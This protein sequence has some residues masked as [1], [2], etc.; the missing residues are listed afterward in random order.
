[1]KPTLKP[2]DPRLTAFALDE[3]SEADRP[4]FAAE[5]KSAPASQQLL[6]EVAETATILREAFVLEEIPTGDIR[7]AAERTRRHIARP[8]IWAQR[9][10]VFAAAASV[11]IAIVGAYSWM[12]SIQLRQQ[13]QAITVEIAKTWDSTPGE[14]TTPE[15]RVT[16]HP[17]AETQIAETW[18]VP[19][20]HPAPRPNSIAGA[21]QPVAPP[22]VVVVET[23]P[24]PSP[25]AAGLR[26]RNDLAFQPVENARESSFSLAIGDSSYQA[27]REA[28]AAGRLPDPDSVRI[29]ELVN[30]FEYD[31]AK[32]ED[33]AAGV[34]V[35]ME[36]A[37][38]PW[39]PRHRLVR[40][41]L[42]GDVLAQVPSGARIQV[43][44]NQY[45]V[46]NY[47]LLGYTG[48]ESADGDESQPTGRHSVTALY[49][50]EPLVLLLKPAT[51]ENPEMFA[52]PGSK[53]PRK[54]DQPREVHLSGHRQAEEFPLPQQLLT[55]KLGS[56]RAQIPLTDDGKFLEDASAD[57]RF[58]AAVAAFGM[59]L[60]GEDVE[61][62]LSFEQIANLAEEALVVADNS[63]ERVTFVKTAQQAAR[64]GRN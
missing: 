17:S 13:N 63:G 49:E 5:L 53:S 60:R 59:R 2:E 21:P 28:L 32:P 27:V 26:Q 52:S 9:I 34:A 47:R 48:P 25:A 23:S 10:T 15:F 11:A 40:I 58:A 43:Q 54:P 37:D 62:Q 19:K 29:E 56:E 42:H 16:V 44:F 18:P 51:S 57:F 39:N 61:N 36:V 20:R 64:L 22:A 3:M 33:S 4:V 38:C 24:K 8:Q 6:E 55:L 45:Q 46:R 30:H 35:D 1:M 31:Y 14:T 7:I 41:G 12:S 50:I